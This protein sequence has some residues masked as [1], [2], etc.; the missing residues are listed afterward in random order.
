MQVLQTIVHGVLRTALVASTLLGVS[1]LAR[2]ALATG[3][4][5]AC[6]PYTNGVPDVNLTFGCA[7]QACAA[8]C[9]VTGGPTPGGPTSGTMRCACGGTVETPS[10]ARLVHWGPTG[11]SVP[12]CSDGTCVIVTCK[13]KDPLPDDPE[14]PGDDSIP[15]TWCNCE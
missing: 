10:C 15:G 1:V 2:A 9:T 6:V 8:A 13:E 12:P 7:K 5:P 14:I 3:G 11:R 4:G